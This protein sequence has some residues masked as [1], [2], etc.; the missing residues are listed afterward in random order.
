MYLCGGKPQAFTH[1]R[2]ALA[3]TL[4]GLGLGHRELTQPAIWRKK[5]G[6]G[7]GAGV[8]EEVPGIFQECHNLTNSGNNFA[9]YDIMM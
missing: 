8:G 5:C 2:N 3:L 4:A 6:A 1:P 7:L 9:N